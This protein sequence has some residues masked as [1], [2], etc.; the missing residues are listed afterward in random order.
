MAAGS[1]KA[2]LA[3]LA[4]NLMI[5]AAKLVAAVVTGSAAMFAETLHSLADSGDQVLLLYGLGRS[6][7]PAD[8][9]HPFG[10]GKEQYFWAFV[11]AIVLFAL[12]CV[13]SLVE[14]FRKVL[15]PHPMENP[16]V[17]FVVLAVS[18][19]FEGASLRVALGEF[20]RFRRGRP[21]FR[22]LAE[23]ED[24]LT[25]TV[26]LEDMAALT[27]LGSAAVFVA[28]AELLH[29][30]AF[31]GLGSIVIGLVLG[32]VA[33]FLARAQ[34]AFLVGKGLSASRVAEIT[35]RVLAVA[36]V[37]GVSEVATMYLGPDM[38]LCA[39]LT[40][41]HGITGDEVVRAIDEVEK[42]LKE[43]VPEAHHVYLEA[44]GIAAAERG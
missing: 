42:V 29:A 7:R 30:P 40:F 34:K 10:H 2:V 1:K 43:V 41:A 20:E 8:E 37:T 17:T 18:M 13:F 44:D 23:A 21:F 3:A 36:P 6:G 19:L 15:E 9:G 35:E 32:V 4:G 24:P 22:A 27:G 14:G 33:Y 12:G 11:V 26:V 28:L 38:L 39:N 25:L 16:V 31:D 5:T